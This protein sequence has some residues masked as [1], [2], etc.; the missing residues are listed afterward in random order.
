MTRPLRIEF[1]GAL[2]HVVSR[3]HRL[4]PIYEDDADREMFLEVLAEAVEQFNWRCLAYCLMT[5]HYHLL[6]QTPEANL[7][8]GMRYV[9]GVYTQSSNRRHRRAGHIFQGRYRAIVV[10][11][12]QY[13]LPVARHIVLNPVRTGTTKVP[14]AWHWS[15]YRATCGDDPAP[16]WLAA[17]ELLRHF[18]SDRREAQKRY[19]VFVLNGVGQKSVWQDVRQ[20]IYLGEDEF[21]RNVQKYLKNPDDP[22]ISRIQR[23]PPAPS[24]GDI[25][26]DSLTRNEAMERAHRTG[27]YSYS[28][29]ARFFG[30]HPSTV[31]RILRERAV[32]PGGRR[33]SARDSGSLNGRSSAAG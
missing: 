22:N 29:I 9:N 17:D 13:L 15:S 26:K 30:V 14:G 28:E 20:Q 23:R 6:V 19:Y 12:E 32:Q 21:I 11:P 18:D 5:N 4:E 3:G 31:S 7:S 10:D 24:L 27:G 33:D 1:P 16:D 2:Y 25:V 8:R